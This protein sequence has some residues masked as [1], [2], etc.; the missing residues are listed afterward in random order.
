MDKTIRIGSRES[1]LAV[2]QS[3]LA[4]KEIQKVMPESEPVLVTMKTTGDRILNRPLDQIGGKGLFVKELDQALRDG[5]CDLTV[6]SLKDMPMEQPEGLPIKA[7]LK[8][9]DSRD[10][11]VLRS[12]LTALPAAPVIGTSSKRRALQAGR[13]FPDAV[14]KG[15]RGNLLTRMKK[16]DAGEYDALILAAAGMLRLG[17]G[18]RISRYF[19]VRE[20]IP[21]AGQGILAIQGRAEDEWPFLAQIDDAKA[22]MLALAERAF[23]RTLDGGCTSPT[24]A[25][26]NLEDGRMTILGLYYEEETDVCRIGSLEGL[27]EEAEQLGVK[28]ALMLKGGETVK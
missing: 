28:L 16:L 27:P 23:V 7:Y 11:L 25:S 10:V 13:L 21:A 17:Y 8:R 5:R 26:S 3:E 2:I 12:G 4:I 6:H 1:A 24:A 9:E 18:E 20:M 19:T 22:R 15:C 14:F